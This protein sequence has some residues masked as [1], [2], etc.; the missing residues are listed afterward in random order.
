MS[1]SE[2]E[3]LRAA[4]HYVLLIPGL[5]EQ[6]LSPEELQEFLMRLLQEH[7][8]LVDADLARYP[9][10]Q[11]QAQRLIDTACELEVCPGETVQGQPV[12]LS[13]RSSTQ[14]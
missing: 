3:L 13:Q 5:P 6:F 2:P 12:R 10:P 4:N 14:S 9:T 7:P 11:A 1:D 8:H